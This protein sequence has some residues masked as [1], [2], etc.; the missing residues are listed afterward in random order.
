VAQ[1]TTICAKHLVNLCQRRAAPQ[2]RLPR[3]ILFRS[4]QVG[5][6]AQA[7]EPVP[8]FTTVIPVRSNPLVVGLN[9]PAAGLPESRSAGPPGRRQL[10]GAGLPGPRS[11]LSKTASPVTAPAPATTSVTPFSQCTDRLASLR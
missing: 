1:I 10:P 8:H 6:C 5:L 11:P 3:T 2:A 9:D 7:F 4:G